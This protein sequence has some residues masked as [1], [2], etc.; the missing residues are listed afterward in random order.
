MQSFALDC[1]ICEMA[2]NQQLSLGFGPAL[3]RKA[4]F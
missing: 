4:V 3:G 2:N 1:A